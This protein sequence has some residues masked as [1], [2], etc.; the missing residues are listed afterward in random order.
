MIFYEPNWKFINDINNQ[1][2]EITLPQKISRSHKHENY[3][4]QQTSQ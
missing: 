2:I 4:L 1:D 3:V